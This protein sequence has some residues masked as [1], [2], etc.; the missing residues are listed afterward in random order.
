MGSSPDSGDLSRF[1]FI[2]Q[3][4]PPSILENYSYFNQKQLNEQEFER[5]KLNISAED[6]Y[7]DRINNL[8]DDSFNS[9][10]KKGLSNNSIISG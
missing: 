6:R 8:K 3:Q 10:S 9:K 2:S 7:P 4:Q 1:N 5:K